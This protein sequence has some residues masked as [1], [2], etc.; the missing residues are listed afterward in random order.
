M[1]TK[2]GNIM[3]PPP[4]RDGNPARVDDGEACTR[5]SRGLYHRIIAASEKRSTR[6]PNTYGAGRPAGRPPAHSICG[7]SPLSLNSST[8]SSTGSRARLSLRR[9]S[10]IGELLLLDGTRQGGDNGMWRCYLTIICFYFAE[11]PQFLGTPGERR[12][13]MSKISW[14]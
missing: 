5:Q 4:R 1:H 2:A 12:F 3:L 8:R 10:I 13:R 9:S 14:V 7:S 11:M 6:K